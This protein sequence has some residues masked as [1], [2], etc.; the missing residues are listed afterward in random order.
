MYDFDAWAAHRSVKRYWR[1][2]IG[3]FRSRIV[4][5]IALVGAPAWVIG[6]ACSWR[7]HVV[8]RAG[9]RRRC[10]APTA[11]PGGIPVGCSNGSQPPTNLFVFAL[12]PAAHPAS[13]PGGHWMRT[14]SRF[15]DRFLGSTACSTL[16]QP[17]LLVFLEATGVCMY[18]TALRSG[19]LPA[20]WRSIQGGPNALVPSTHASSWLTLPCVLFDGFAESGSRN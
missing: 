12:C 4:A 15:Q 18:E 19:A 8:Q 13:V 7:D 11:V 10:E 6:F 17:I 2:F 5:G 20:T 16:V 1:H 9:S 3:L 14:Y